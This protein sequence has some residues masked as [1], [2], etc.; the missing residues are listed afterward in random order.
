MIKRQLG[1]GTWS[2]NEMNKCSRPRS[3]YLQ[4]A[5][6]REW[7]RY[8][9]RAFTE[10]RVWEIGAAWAGEQLMKSL[11]NCV[12]HVSFIQ[13]LGAEPDCLPDTWHTSENKAKSN[14]CPYGAA[15]PVRR[16]KWYTCYLWFWKW[17][18]SICP[19]NGYNLSILPISLSQ[20]KGYLIKI[21]LQ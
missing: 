12:Q 3:S 15:L 6:I 11:T 13:Q 18:R 17:T 20:I 5:D 9:F 7:S 16:E 21:T 2:R 1:K 8:L 10:S 19:P 14:A 4:K